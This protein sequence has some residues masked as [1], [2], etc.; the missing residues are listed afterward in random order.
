MC[1]YRLTEFTMG[2]M[3]NPFYIDQG[4]T[5]DQIA[6]VVK[7]FGLS[8]SIVGT[9]LAGIVI[10]KIG[11]L[12]ALVLGSLMIMTSN[13]GFSILASTHTA[14]LVGIAIVNSVDNLAQAMHGI[15]LIVFLS[16]LTS[17]KYTATQ[18]A[19]FSSLYALLG[20]ALEGTSGFV[21]DAIGYPRFFLYTA[22]LS[23][24]AL[25]LLYWIAKRPSI[26]EELA[27]ASR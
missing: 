11:M 7:V 2:S 9:V 14:T 17:Q 13:I 12:R 18:Y 8:T 23:I 21:V 5:L 24:P 25:L 16:S 26:R 3:A 27:A 1:T 22:S 19:L 4:Y 15:A 20:K 10:S 6:S